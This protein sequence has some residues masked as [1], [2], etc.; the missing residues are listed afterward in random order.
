MR[1]RAGVPLV[2][3]LACAGV[4]FAGAILQDWKLAAVGALLALIWAQVAL[5]RLMPPRYGLS[6]TARWTLG[7]I[8]TIGLSYY[9]HVAQRSIVEVGLLLMF[10]IGAGVYAFVLSRRRAPA[11]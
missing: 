3:L 2:F 1:W 4:A 5:P 8:L 9:A 11:R 7:A 6:S 10:G